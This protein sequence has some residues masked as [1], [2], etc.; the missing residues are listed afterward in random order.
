MGRCTWLLWPVSSCVTPSDSTF[1]HAAGIS[2]GLWL[3]EQL[4]SSHMVGRAQ[5]RRLS[6]EWEIESKTLVF[7]L[8]WLTSSFLIKKHWFKFI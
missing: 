7:E 4:A 1:L 5:S 6:T 8:L 2:V 3:A